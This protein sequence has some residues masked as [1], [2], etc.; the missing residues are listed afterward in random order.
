MDMLINVFKID[1]GI[2]LS[3]PRAVVIDDHCHQRE[4]A[5]APGIAYT[6]GILRK[7]ERET[8]KTIMNA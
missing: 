2:S 1:G 4:E 8:L 3:R 7:E 6:K 5:G